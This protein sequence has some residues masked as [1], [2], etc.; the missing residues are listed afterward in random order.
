MPALRKRDPVDA[1]RLP[2][3]ITIHVEG[4]RPKP[5]PKG[6]VVVRNRS[7]RKVYILPPDEVLAIYVG[8]DA[9][10]EALMRELEGGGC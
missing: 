4:K 10:G 9:E 8:D 5:F 6:C 1:I 2:W 7:N 3:A